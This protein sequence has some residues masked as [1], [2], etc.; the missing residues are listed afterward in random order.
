M[1]KRRMLSI[2]FCESDHFYMLSPVTR[3]LYVH[4][5]LNADDDG[6][7]DKWRTVM[8]CAR[9]E[10]K[11]Y[12]PLVD[13]EY[14][15][16]INEGLI[17]ITHWHRHNT[18]RADRYVA[19]AYAKALRGFSVNEEKR[20]IKASENVLVAQRDPQIREDKSITD[21]SRSDKTRVEKEK[22]SDFTTNNQTFIHTSAASQDK[23]K[24]EALSFFDSKDESLSDER[25]IIALKAAIGLYFI[26]KYQS[27][28]SKKF[29]EYYEKRDWVADYERITS[30]N[31]KYYVDK[32]MKERV[33]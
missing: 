23:L 25:L 5:I 26:K 24:D 32:W 30:D 8:R 1:A 20:Y 33:L 9:I 31:Y 13:Q 12:K 15:I 18:I 14:V 28:E 22:K 27:L 4:F 6:F 19:T 17:L 21:K 29:I 10:K 3:M 2:D 7:V 11:F 16:E